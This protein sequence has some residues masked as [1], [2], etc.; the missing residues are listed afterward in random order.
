MAKSESMPE[1]NRSGNQTVQ[2]SSLVAE[3]QQETTTPAWHDMPESP[4]C[5][6]FLLLHVAAWMSLQN[7]SACEAQKAGIPQ[8][9]EEVSSFSHPK[10]LVAGVHQEKNS[11]PCG[12]L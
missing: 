7:S 11:L 10:T 6:N 5:Y 2:E 4:V 9:A 1:S 12:T 8:H 3:N